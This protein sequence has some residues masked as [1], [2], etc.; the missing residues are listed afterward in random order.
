M[1]NNN[2]QQTEKVKK[3]NVIR[4]SYTL[5]IW[6]FWS[7]NQEAKVPQGPEICEKIEVHFAMTGGANKKF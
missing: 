2:N 7:K 5:E 1:D 4:E 6:I 3:N